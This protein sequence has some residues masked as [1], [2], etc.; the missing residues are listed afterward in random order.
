VLKGEG[1]DEIGGPGAGSLKKRE[2][3]AWEGQSSSGKTGMCEFREGTSRKKE[4]P[5]DNEASTKTPGGRTYLSEKGGKRLRRERKPRVLECQKHATN[6]C[7][8]KREKE[9]ERGTKRNKGPEGMFGR[10]SAGRKLESRKEVQWRRLL[11]PPK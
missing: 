8:K 2:R 7:L 10:G 6:N 9:G 5:G 1:L 3:I 11:H 4:R